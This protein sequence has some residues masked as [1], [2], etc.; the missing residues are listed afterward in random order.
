MKA[1]LYDKIKLD[2]GFLRKLLKRHCMPNDYSAYARGY[3]QALAH[4]AESIKRRAKV[5]SE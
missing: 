3:N 5:E 2:V 1:S 4:I